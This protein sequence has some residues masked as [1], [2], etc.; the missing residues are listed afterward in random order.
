MDRRLANANL[1]T[2]IFAAS[3]AVA[4]FALTFVAAM[5]FV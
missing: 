4:I 3:L 1:R 2:G 5:L